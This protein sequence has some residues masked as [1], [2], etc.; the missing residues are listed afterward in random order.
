MLSSLFKSIFSPRET[1]RPRLPSIPSCV[2]YSITPP[3]VA[4]AGSTQLL[5]CSFGYYEILDLI[6]QCQAAQT[7]QLFAG[8]RPVTPLLTFGVNQPASFAGIFLYW[9]EVLTIVCGNASTVVV[10]IRYKHYRA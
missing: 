6:V 5:R 10:S 7:F 9:P 1:T 2:E 4:A 8:S 3:P